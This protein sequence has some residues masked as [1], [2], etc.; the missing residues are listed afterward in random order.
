MNKLMLIEKMHNL[1]TATIFLTI[2]NPIHFC[3]NL[4]FLRDIETFENLE[5]CRVHNFRDLFNRIGLTHF[6]VFMSDLRINLIPALILVC[7]ICFDREVRRIRLARQN[8]QCR[9]HD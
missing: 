5:L 6:I 9:A 8:S 7:L 2:E 4:E 3:F 1:N